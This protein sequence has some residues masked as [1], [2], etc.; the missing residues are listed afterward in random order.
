M[1][2]PR[3]E[4]RAKLL[5]AFVRN[6]TSSSS[7]PSATLS[8]SLESI[9]RNFS[10]ASFKAVLSVGSDCAATYLVVRFVPSLDVPLAS[11]DGLGSRRNDG[12]SSKFRLGGLAGG[13][14]AAGLRFISTGS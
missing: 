9:K 10:R 2:L 6:R 12:K 3:C 8:D 5:K 13:E 1:L 4:F 7:K 11:E 14:N